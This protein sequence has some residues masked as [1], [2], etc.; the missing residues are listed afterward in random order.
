VVLVPPVEPEPSRRFN[1]LFTV[2]G[3]GIQGT[4]NTNLY[5]IYKFHMAIL[6]TF[7]NILQPNVE[8][9][10]NLGCSFQL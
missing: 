6:S 2:E 7:Y 3:S 5:K 10:L 4:R 9:L 1:L 8:I